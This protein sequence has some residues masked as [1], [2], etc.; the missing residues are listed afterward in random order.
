MPIATLLGVGFAALGVILTVQSNN[1]TER[2]REASA[3]SVQADANTAAFRLAAAEIVM[4]QPT[5]KLAEARARELIK[6]FPTRLSVPAFERFTQPLSAVLCKEIKASPW[7]TFSKSN[8]TTFFNSAAAN[9]FQKKAM[10]PR[11]R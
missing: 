8:I 9:P 11:G 2:A 3:A 1:A 5:C 7:I 4:A 10:K 6:L